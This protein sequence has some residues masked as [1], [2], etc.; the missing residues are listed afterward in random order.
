MK[1]NIDLDWDYLY[2]LP[3]EEYNKFTEKYLEFA[4][5]KLIEME[6]DCCKKKGK[7]KNNLTPKERNNM[8]LAINKRRDGKKLGENMLRLNKLFWKA[9]GSHSS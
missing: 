4:T 7:T 5:N 9:I 6:N 8:R 2:K 3:T 1:I